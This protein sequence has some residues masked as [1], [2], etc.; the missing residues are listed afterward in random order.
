MPATTHARLIT[1]RQQAFIASL[2]A[3]RDHADQTAV[4]H[5]AEGMLSSRDASLLI[6][7]LSAAPRRAAATPAADDS[8][9]VPRPS[10]GNR[11]GRMLAA[12][13]I[14]ATVTLPTGEHVTLT[15]RTRRRSGR[16][17]T[18]ASPGEPTARTT[19]TA[20]GRRV[21]WLNVDG[22]GFWRLTLRTRN[23]NVQAALGAL[24]THAAGGW[25]GDLGRV[26]VADRCG[27][28]MRALTDPVSI[29][30]GVG[31]ECLGR[32]TGS[33][34][35]SVAEPSPVVTQPQ[36]AVERDAYEAREPR[37]DASRSIRERDAHDAAFERAQEQAAYEAEMREERAL[38]IG[39]PASITALAAAA[40]PDADLAQARDLI[41][42][43]LDAH[44][45][46]A[47]RDF[48]MRIFDRL[49]AR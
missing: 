43:A 1:A 38:G 8:V 23:A 14:D 17:W 40:Q 5:A 41:A 2:A 6:D 27:R 10:E 45:T 13:G 34:H 32:S 31:P 48:A 9:A 11:A 21:G 3:E 33:R 47:D 22:D 37:F 18:N 7:R 28:C 16:G 26:Q 24:F 15:I 35:A 19:V 49:A 42:E 4:A 20:L 30:R 12:G 36:S 39:A 25:S 46:D 29:D 44:C